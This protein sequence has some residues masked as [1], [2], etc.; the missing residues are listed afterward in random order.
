MARF[1]S[2]VFG[3]GTKFGTTGLTVAEQ[4]LFDVMAGQTPA[5]PGRSVPVRAACAEIHVF[6]PATWAVGVK[7]PYV[8][9]GATRQASLTGLGFQ[10]ETLTFTVANPNDYYLGGAGDSYLL[11]GAWLCVQWTVST[12]TADTTVLGGV[13][14]VSTRPSRERQAGVSTLQ[15]TA[16]DWAQPELSRKSGSGWVPWGDLQGALTAYEASGLPQFPGANAWGSVLGGW[17]LGHVGVADALRVVP[18]Y[19][20]TGFAV[21]TV[22]AFQQVGDPGKPQ[23]AYDVLTWLW[24]F[25]GGFTL[26]YGVDGRLLLY[27]GGADGTDSGCY[28][29]TDTT[30]VGATPLPWTSPLTR[31]L[32]HP[33]FA[34]SEYYQHHTP[35]PAATPGTSGAED[36][37]PALLGRMVSAA[38]VNPYDATRDNTDVVVDTIPE[39]E[40]VLITQVSVMQPLSFCTW[41][42]STAL[43]PAD[44]I[45]VQLDSAFPPPPLG[46]LIR[47]HAPDEVDGW[48]RLVSF[49]QP[50]GAALASYQCQWWSDS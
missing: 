38:A 17:V 9:A 10:Q 29:S 50:L 36:H 8:A 23:T 11:P 47:I 3:D 2:F 43:G 22:T 37:G 13:Y 18:W 31:Q 1:G 26:A 28:I 48:Y 34:A 42:L 7:L 45:S 14:R 39:P 24:P 16:V 21:P 46:K 40:G 12:A 30:V 27:R 44:T 20:Q 33:S 41:R 15:V 49:S 19:T 5:L 4:A 35:D 32:S 6:N 25:V